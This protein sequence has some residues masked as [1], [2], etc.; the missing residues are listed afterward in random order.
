MQS[1]N[2]PHGT[3]QAVQTHLK[4]TVH[5]TT[6]T[7]AAKG[8]FSNKAVLQREALLGTIDCSKHGSSEHNNA[9]L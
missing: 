3:T 1:I 2:F 4:S 9:C 5:H 6:N 7:E 8:S